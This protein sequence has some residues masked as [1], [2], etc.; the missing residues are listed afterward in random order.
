MARFAHCRRRTLMVATR[1][2]HC[3]LSH[4]LHCSHYDNS[5]QID[6]IL[7]KVIGLISHIPNVL[8]IC[9]PFIQHRY[10]PTITAWI[11]T[12]MAA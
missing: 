1:L 7:F 12:R 5:I 11:V 3:F 10:I 8:L 2:V 4:S 9:E 6:D